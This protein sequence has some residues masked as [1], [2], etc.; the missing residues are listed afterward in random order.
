MNIRD[1]EGYKLNDN[2]I[3][4]P[5]TV[6]GSFDNATVKV[7]KFPYN[8]KITG[9]SFATGAALG[10]S[11]GIDV[12]VGEAKAAS[13]TDNLNG[14]ELKTADT[15]ITKDSEISVVFDDFTAATQCVVNIYI[16]QLP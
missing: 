1:K 10:A 16:Q 5:I 13:C 11:A 6:C 3:V 2:P 14:Y 8:G 4:V 7:G 12:M 15:S 9:V